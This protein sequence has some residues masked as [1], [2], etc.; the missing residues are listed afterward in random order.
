MV[1][2]VTTWQQGDCYIMAGIFRIRIKNLVVLNFVMKVDHTL[3]LRLH[4]I[5]ATYVEF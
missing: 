3:Q 1:D 2:V 4:K 5:W